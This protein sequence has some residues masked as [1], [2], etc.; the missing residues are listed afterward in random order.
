MIQDPLALL[1]FMF[2]VVAFARALGSRFEFVERISTTP[3][4]EMWFPTPEELLE[5]GL[6]DEVAGK[7]RGDR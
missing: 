1:A 2:L 3:W 4:D 7:A 5:S 6:V